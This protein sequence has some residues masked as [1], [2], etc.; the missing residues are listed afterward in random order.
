[1]AVV[2]DGCIHRR[3]VDDC[4]GIYAVTTTPDVLMGG[5]LLVH[6]SIGFLFS[7]LLLLLP[8]VVHNII[9]IIIHIII[10]VTDDDGDDACNVGH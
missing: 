8:V 10:I 5:L 3:T 6:G 9:I 7:I 4:C 1:M 2:G